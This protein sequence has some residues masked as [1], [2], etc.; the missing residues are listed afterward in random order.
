VTGIPPETVAPGASPAGARTPGTD[1]SGTDSPSTGSPGTGNPGTGNRGTGTAGTAAPGARLP[2]GATGERPPA[3]GE[4][5]APEPDP[6]AEVAP[7]LAEIL[8]RHP[9]SDRAQDADSDRAPDEA[10]RG[11]PGEHVTLDDAVAGGRSGR[12]IGAGRRFLARVAAGPGA[13]THEANGP[14]GPRGG[15]VGTAAVP[16]V[17]PPGPGADRVPELTAVA[18]RRPSSRSVALVAGT[19]ALTVVLVYAAAVLFWDVRS[20][21]LTVFI[22]LFL[23]IGFDPVIRGLQRVVRRRGLAVALFLVLLLGLLAGFSVIALVPAVNQL[24]QLATSIP[25]IIQEAQDTNSTVGKFLSRPEVSQRINDFV[26]TLPARAVGSAG[27]VFGV[28]LTILGGAV[29]TFAVL[30]LMIYFMLSM[31][32]MLR[33][34]GAA[35]G[36]GERATV[37]REALSKV[38]GYVTG[39][40]TVCACSGIAS[41]TFFVIVG[42]PYAAVLAIAV[43]IFDA[44]PQVGATFGAGVSTLI[45]LTQSVTLG[46]GTLVFFLV[47]QQVENYVIAPR[48]FARSVNLSAVGVLIAVLVGGSVSGIVGALLAL[49]TAA[50]LKTVL[51]YSFRD[52]LGRIAHLQRRGVERPTA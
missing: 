3:L 14:T 29:T 1:S 25:G 4:M 8:G 40:L 11:T 6:D 44:I 2:R 32:R 48:L 22:A 42:M 17:A 19:A 35:V 20:V 5:S 36:G 46:V 38:G 47:Y 43:A 9:D 18:L 16:P 30:A 37:L 21:L 12:V 10:G 27:T 39:Q 33:F 41:A 23:A 13:A 26:G 52:Q 31:P 50:A 34:A 45:G 15:P 7:D 51:A 24:T 49:P 28:I